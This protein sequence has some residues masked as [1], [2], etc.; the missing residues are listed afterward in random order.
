ME[1]DDVETDPD[2]GATNGKIGCLQIDSNCQAM[3]GD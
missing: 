1:A 2:C 3:R